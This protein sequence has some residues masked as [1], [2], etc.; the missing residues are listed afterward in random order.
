MVATGSD[1]G[2]GDGAGNAN[3]R[4]V[5]GRLNGNGLAMAY[6]PQGVAPQVSLALRRFT[7]VF[8]MGTGGATA[9]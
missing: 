8:G 5:D 9:L 2:N 4:R 7:S 3:A 1:P 6:F